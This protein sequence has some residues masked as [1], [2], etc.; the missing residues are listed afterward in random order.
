MI[1]K[2]IDALDT[3]SVRHPVLRA[4]KPVTSCAMEGDHLDTTIHLGA[5]LKDQLVGVATLVAS[6]ANLSPVRTIT[7]GSYYQLRGMAVLPHLQG[8]GVGKKLIDEC[9]QQ[10]RDRG[11]EMLW[12]NARIKAVPFYERL[13]FTK[14]GDVFEIEGIGPHYKMHMSL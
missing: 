3:Y 7:T 6:S 5:F 10:L 8:H 1:I 4:G 9:L 12:F 2:V 13:G 11:I 14:S